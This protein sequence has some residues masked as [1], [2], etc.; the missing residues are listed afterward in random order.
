MTG[1][2]RFVKYSSYTHPMQQHWLLETHSLHCTPAQ[3][4]HKG[5]S[6]LLSCSFSTLTTV[7]VSVPTPILL[8][9][10]MTQ[11]FFHCSLDLKK[12]VALLELNLVKTKEMVID[13][14]HQARPSGHTWSRSGHCGPVQIPLRHHAEFWGKHR[15]HNLKNP[16]SKP[17]TS[18]SLRASCVFPSYVG[19]NPS[20]SKTEAA[21]RTL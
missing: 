11:P 9:L 21:S 1:F 15:S 2:W 16:S 12:T 13:F 3:V 19:S 14:N 20:Q 5:A 7:R 17:S 18:L 6:F 4:H 10:R 8:N